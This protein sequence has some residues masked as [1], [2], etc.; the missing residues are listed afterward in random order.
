[1][2]TIGILG[3]THDNE[4]RK[5]IG[6]TL[7]FIEELIL[8]FKPDVLCGE[9]LPE[10]WE[11]Y[12]QE[13]LF[14]GCVGEPAS[15]YGELI[16][17]L[18]EK[19]GIEFV[20]IDWLELDVWMDFDPFLAIEGELRNKLELERTEWEQKQLSTCGIGPIPLNSAEYDSITKAMYEWMER[21]NPEAHIFRWECRH[22]IMIQRIK[23]A[24]KRHPG[25]RILCIV[26]ADHNYKLY[27]SLAAEEGIEL[28]Y[29]L[30]T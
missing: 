8:E 20:P 7:E 22:L 1:M 16:I 14:K 4:R 5:R 28:V 2:T 19:Q 29:P 26:G 18:C 6:L 13:G 11:R 12:Q 9:M 25:K 30:R 15:E 21:I 27:E 10:S 3:V 23:N 24:V 17:P